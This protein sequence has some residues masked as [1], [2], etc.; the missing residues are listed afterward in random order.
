MPIL[1]G[2]L[3]VLRTE[4]YQQIFLT[5]PVETHHRKSQGTEH[6]HL[7]PTL[8]TIVYS[9]REMPT[10][11]RNSELPIVVA[12]GGNKRPFSEFYNENH[13][14]NLNYEFSGLQKKTRQGV[15]GGPTAYSSSIPHN[16]SY[17]NGKEIEIK[18][19]SRK[20][21]SKKPRPS[22]ILSDA[23]LV[24]SI[25]K[26]QNNSLAKL[27][28]GDFFENQRSEREIVP[29]KLV[30]HEDGAEDQKRDIVDVDDFSETMMMNMPL[31]ASIASTSSSS[32]QH[33]SK[34]N[35]EESKLITLIQAK[36]WRK[37]KQRCQKHPS[38]TSVW[39]T[40]GMKHADAKMDLPIHV[41]LL[42]PGV[43]LEIVQQ[44]LIA[45]P[46]STIIKNSD[47]LS[48]L[49]IVCA[50]KIDQR[51]ELV[52]L[53]LKGH[54]QS[55]KIKSKRGDLPIHLAC[56]SSN[57]KLQVIEA[58]LNAFPIAASIPGEMERLALQMACE[59]GVNLS[60]LKAVYER[61]RDAVLWKDSFDALPLHIACKHAPEQLCLFI[62][63]EYQYG[64]QISDCWDKLPLH[65]ACEF[66]GSHSLIRALLLK[67]PEALS[68]RDTTG[69]TPTDFAKIN[70]TENSRK[71]LQVLK[72]HGDMLEKEKEQKEKGEVNKA[73]NGNFSNSS[74][75]HEINDVRSE[76]GD[77][78][79]MLDKILQLI[80]EKK[81]QD[82]AGRNE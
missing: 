35:H 36:K 68:M 5:S 73:T 42:Q 33:K 29:K 47:G 71:I 14:N 11:Y 25:G 82:D 49:H 27:G 26:V 58:L 24:F 31:L 52:Q 7:I 78:K 1:I 53:F 45:K 34:R 65:Y 51:Y 66:N 41:A 18:T 10:P 74:L 12:S 28:N 59:S 21:K 75:K 54:P 15:N 22:P 61:C 13:C 43:P 37:V 19:P 46:D 4:K 3:T 79:G 32:E 76:L 62:L 67:H 39:Y 57:A 50:D 77:V 63:G 70:A 20:R 48:P 40:Y 56:Q 17:S 9:T 30:I 2:V 80:G 23:P 55:P 38:E 44:L 64:S 6:S 60:V 16:Y 69:K 72:D 8:R 81:V